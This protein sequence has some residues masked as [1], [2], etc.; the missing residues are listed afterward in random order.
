[1]NIFGEGLPKEIIDQINTR[2]KAYGSGYNGAS[3]TPEEITYLN[4]NT[5][6]CKLISSVNIKDINSINSPTVKSLD[7]KDDTLAK[8]FML[9]NGTSEYIDGLSKD[10]GGI[11]LDKSL[12][13]GTGAYGIGGTDFGIKPMM[14]IQSI[15][16]THENRGS[17]RRATVKAKAYNKAQF[18]I[19]DILYMRLGFSVL[20]EW[21][22]SMYYKKDG[23][24]ETNPHDSLDN[25]FING[26]FNY[27]EMLK[28]IHQ[29]RLD[30]AGNYDAMFAKVSN[31][32]WSF[33]KDG[34]YDITINLVSIGDIIESLKVNILEGN[35]LFNVPKSS[36]LPTD[37]NS[38]K[39]NIENFLYLIK[40][41]FNIPPQKKD[42]KNDQNLYMSVKDIDLEKIGNYVTEQKDIEQI[43][44]KIN[45]SSE[46]KY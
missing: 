1:M 41:Q 5:S 11:N 17:L 29:Q 32:S 43:Q 27:D 40:T 4:A 36:G 19:I 25:K 6:W 35:A 13:G 39:S 20:L 23:T 26:G 46:P 31:F 7:L 14:G 18:E 21:G 38:N 15:S 3:R 10:R 30:T 33:H 9:F 24:L 37:P 16:I 44:T 42:E 34:S 8:K 12:I 45:S 2:Q 22:N 28:A